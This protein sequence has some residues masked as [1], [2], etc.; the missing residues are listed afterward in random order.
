A[1][2]L[3][4][5]RHEFPK[6]SEL[7]VAAAHLIDRT[8]T[9]TCTGTGGRLAWA[10]QVDSRCAS[11]RI[12]PVTVDPMQLW[13]NVGAVSEPD[14]PKEPQRVSFVGHVDD[15]SLEHLYGTN[16]CVVAP[17]FDEDYGLTAIEAMRFGRPV[18]VCSDGGGLAELV[19]DGVTGLVVEPTPSAIAAAIDRLH[20][21]D[22]LAD[23]LGANARERAADFSWR[24]AER[25][26][27]DAVT[28]VLD[29]PPREI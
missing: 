13:C 8:V 11:G 3:C 17:A 14:E 21:D 24:R 25:Q 22:A 20:G 2:A 29:A 27:L 16:R 12:D 7:V 6:R 23:E 15:R 9:V 5:S 10:R 18:I 26:L 28:A 19:E 1:G 4:V